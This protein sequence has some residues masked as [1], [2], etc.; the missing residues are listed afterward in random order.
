[1]AYAETKS[2]VALCRNILQGVTD[3]TASTAPSIDEVEMWLSSGCSIIEARLSGEGY[4][5]PPTTTAV[6]YDWL[7]Q[8]NSLYAASFAEM[9]RVNVTLG[10][11][12]RTRGQVF[13]KMFWDGLDRLCNTDLTLVGLSRISDDKIYVGGTTET[14]KEIWEDDTDRVT[15]RLKRGMFNLEGTIRPDAQDT[16]DDYDT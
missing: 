2:V 8:L 16:T 14:Q 7:A 9:S 1:M 3:F 5:V 12:E 13:E 10:P 11:G 15:P 4:S 6:V